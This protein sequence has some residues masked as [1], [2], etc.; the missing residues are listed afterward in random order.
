MG[1]GGGGRG[2]EALHRVIIAV[3]IAVVSGAEPIVLS[4]S[5]SRSHP[6]PAEKAVKSVPPHPT[7]VEVAEARPLSAADSIHKLNV[8]IFRSPSRLN[9]SSTA[10]IDTTPRPTKKNI[11]TSNPGPSRSAPTAMLE[12]PMPSICTAT[13]ETLV[14]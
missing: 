14:Q 12:I 3:T 2:G 13:T 11:V 6:T 4:P 8:C 7:A 5:L 10:A 1:W 9:I